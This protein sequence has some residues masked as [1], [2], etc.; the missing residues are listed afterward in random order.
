MSILRIFCPLSAT[1]THCAWALLDE[2]ADVQCGEGSLQQL[3]RTAARVDLVVA[4]S[5]VLLMRAHLPTTGKRRSAA[6]LAYAAEEKMASDPD[7]NL[8]S[9]LG[10]VDGEDVLAV[11]DRKRLQSWRDA[12]AAVGVHIDGVYCQTLM[13]PLSEGEW[14][15]AWNGQDGYVRTGAFEG[16][17]VDCGDAQTPPLAL[18]LLLDAARAGNTLPAAIALQVTAGAAQP[19]TQA[20]ERALGVRVRIAPAHD[21]RSAATTTGIR[22]E[23]ERRHWQPEAATLSGLRRVGWIVL[24]ALVLHSTALLAD[25]M[26]LGGQQQHLRQQMDARFRAL[27]PAAVAVAD[28]ALQTRRQLASARH[29]AGQPDDGDFAAMLAKVATA[30]AHVPDAKLHAVSYADGRM[31]L[32]LAKLDDAHAKQVGTRLAQ[33]GFLVERAPVPR[34]GA[35]G[36]LTLTLRSP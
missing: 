25:R 13:L 35:G 20:W 22:I 31:T 32:D 9:R 16:G 28:P 15:L 23:Q 2:Q 12:L 5:Q 30:L 27:Y 1:A 24:A 21:W 18:Q 11:I 6:L 7:A 10:Q 17:A 34:G 33:I 26:R 8:V 3:P 36:T 19:E 4:A 29:V 14:S